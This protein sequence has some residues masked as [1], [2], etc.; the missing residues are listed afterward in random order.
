[1][2]FRYVLHSALDGPIAKSIR[3][4]NMTAKRVLNLAQP[5]NEL[6][7]ITLFCP[8]PSVRSVLV[9]FLCI[10]IWFGKLSVSGIIAAEKWRERARAMVH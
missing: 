3:E 10:Y 2:L 7:L 1:M 4:K 6:Y 9:L 8:C 5:N